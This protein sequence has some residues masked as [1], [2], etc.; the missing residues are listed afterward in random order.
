M[1]NLL[2]VILISSLSAC[3]TAP[4]KIKQAKLL[5]DAPAPL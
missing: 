4:I 5:L 3:S 1:K 2:L